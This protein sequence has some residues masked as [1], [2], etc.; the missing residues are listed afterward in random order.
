MA[1]AADS[2][3]PSHPSD[4]DRAFVRHPPGLAYLAFMEAF[5]RFSFLGI[6]LLD[7]FT[8][9]ADNVR[10][11]LPQLMR[12]AGFGEVSETRRYTTVFGTMSLYRAQKKS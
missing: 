12:D 3:L 11:L 7:G 8:T 10:G 1:I 4:V 9:T 5:E 2:P 6:Q